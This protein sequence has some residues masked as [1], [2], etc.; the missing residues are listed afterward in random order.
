[1][2]NTKELQDLAGGGEIFGVASISEDGCNISCDYSKHT[3]VLL[4]NSESKN[5]WIKHGEDDLT[6]NRTQLYYQYSG[7]H[8]S[9]VETKSKM[10]YGGG[11]EFYVPE[12]LCEQ[13]SDGDF[14]L[15]P[16]DLTDAA[17]QQ[18]ILKGQVWAKNV[19]LDAYHK[20]AAN[21]LALFGGYFGLAFYKNKEGIKLKRLRV[22]SHLTMRLGGNRKEINNEFTSD[23][24][25]ISNDWSKAKSF[26][27]RRWREID[28]SKDFVGRIPAEDFSVY[29]TKEIQTP[30]SKYFGNVTSYKKYYG[31][32]D[33]ESKKTLNYFEVDYLFSENDKNDLKNNFSLDH[34]II[35]FRQQGNDKAEEKKLKERDVAEFK[36][37]YKGVFGKRM[38]MMWVAPNILPDGKVETVDPIKIIEI[39]H[40]KS[41]GR[42]NQIREE[43]TIAILSAHGM[44]SPEIAAIPNVSKGNSLSNQSDMLMTAWELIYWSRIQPMQDIIE[45]DINERLEKEGLKLKV[46]TKRNAPVMKAL[47][48]SLLCKAYTLDE[49]RNKYGDSELTEE[50]RDELV[51]NQTVTDELQ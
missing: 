2:F 13:D 5:K 34:I 46:K 23:T 14:N 29:Q 37:N 40:A 28:K 9:I 4:S 51:P 36:T 31:T 30:Y 25:L 20:K 39:P 35:R 48:E 11:F 1:M 22:E 38:A 3:M 17:K 21:E 49:I 18:E 8:N 7:I 41:T 50:Q 33:Y 44:V 24:H 19:L 15:I 16:N 43:R 45:K 42:F 6:P 26:K 47:S 27:V 12:M 32:P 10:I